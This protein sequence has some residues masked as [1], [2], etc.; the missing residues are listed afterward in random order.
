MIFNNNIKKLIEVSKANIDRLIVSSHFNSHLSIDGTIQNIKDA[1]DEK[2]SA[3]YVSQT[4]I[5]HM[6]VMA[7]LNNKANKTAAPFIKHISADELHL[8]KFHANQGILYSTH[9]VF[10]GYTVGSFTTAFNVLSGSKT[11]SST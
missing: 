5:N 8:R 7:D 9:D 3:D 4:I 11:A 6:I 10:S 1:Y 2:V